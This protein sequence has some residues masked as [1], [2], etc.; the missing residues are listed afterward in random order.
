ME[1][2]VKRCKRIFKHSKFSSKDA[3]KF[4]QKRQKQKKNQKKQKILIKPKKLKRFK[5][6]AHNSVQDAEVH[7][8][9]QENVKGCKIET[10]KTLLNNEKPLLKDAK[11]T[12]NQ[13]KDLQEIQKK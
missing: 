13:S 3:K 9:M 2:N 4:Q 10:T 5:R 6:N 12:F 1:N 7:Q 8:K 11:K